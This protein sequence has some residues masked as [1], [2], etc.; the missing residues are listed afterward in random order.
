[1]PTEGFENKSRQPALR[2]QE[3]TTQA[4]QDDASFRDEEVRPMT[5][6]LLETEVNVF[7]KNKGGQLTTSKLENQRSE[8]RAM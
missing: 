8:E 7:V 3:R 4:G 1:M 5:F 6:S 2:K